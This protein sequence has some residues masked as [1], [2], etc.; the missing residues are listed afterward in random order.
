MLN[1]ASQGCAQTHRG[2]CL[3]EKG[4]PLS[5][6]FK[7]MVQYNISSS[8]RYLRMFNTIINSH[9]G[10]DLL[11]FLYLY[12]LYIVWVE[13]RYNCKCAGYRPQW[14]VLTLSFDPDYF[15][16]ERVQSFLQQSF[17]LL[18]IQEAV[19]QGLDF[20]LTL[21]ERW[22]NKNVYLKSSQTLCQLCL[23]PEWIV[24]DLQ[25]P[26]ILLSCCFIDSQWSG[27]IV[28]CHVCLHGDSIHDGRGSS[29][30]QLPGRC[31]A[32]R[33][34]APAPS[35]PSSGC[36]RPGSSPAVSCASPSSSPRTSS[37][38]CRDAPWWTLHQC[39]HCSLVAEGSEN[40]LVRPQK[41]CYM[42]LLHVCFCSVSLQVL[43]WV[44]AG[45]A[46]TFN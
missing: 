16:I 28:S 18:H 1:N 7:V 11:L 37:C 40:T 23:H 8:P 31:G 15:L 32:G 46:T 12:Y 9:K 43:C 27:T 14:V 29:E 38:W 24:L 44:L 41:F 3:S 2:R 26:I 13:P 39:G 34:S 22:K 30:Q 19:C 42:Y 21:M 5:S 33:K 10:S 17:L 4:V 45:M 36:S 35:Y 20:C 25:R 6:L